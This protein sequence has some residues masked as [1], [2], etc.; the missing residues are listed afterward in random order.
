M[1]VSAAPVVSGA[2][3]V[4][5]ANCLRATYVGEVATDVEMDA[6]QLFAARLRG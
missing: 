5:A 4:F 3:D 6:V 2:P 1:D